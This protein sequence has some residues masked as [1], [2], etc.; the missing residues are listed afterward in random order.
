MNKFAWN[1]M[2]FTHYWW[3]VT[4]LLVICNKE[5]I[6]AFQTIVTRQMISNYI[7]EF[8]QLERFLASETFKE[9]Q[10]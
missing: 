9:A 10:R 2:T 6:C 4:E 7:T 8:K 5:M 3:H 1:K